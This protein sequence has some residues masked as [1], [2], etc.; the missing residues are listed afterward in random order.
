MEKCKPCTR[1]P[2]GQIVQQECTRR[3]DTVCVPEK[4]KNNSKYPR[5]PKKTSAAVATTPQTRNRTTITKRRRW[6]SSPKHPTTESSKC[7]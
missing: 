3:R 5:K 6:T 2:K 7:V 4:D 1:C